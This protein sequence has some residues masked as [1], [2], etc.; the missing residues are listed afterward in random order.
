MSGVY[1]L[2]LLAI[3]SVLFIE[4]LDDEI[5]SISDILKEYGK[6]ILYDIPKDMYYTIDIVFIISDV[7]FMM[8]YSMRY[9]ENI[10]TNM[11]IIQIIHL[12]LFVVVSIMMSVLYCGVSMIQ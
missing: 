9:P 8:L 2:L 11:I 7:V 3:S 4:F 12:I 1:V 5:L 10:L 6:C